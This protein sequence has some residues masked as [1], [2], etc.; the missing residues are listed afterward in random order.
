MTST[1]LG[2]VLSISLTP[3]RVREREELGS[4]TGPA[5]PEDSPDELGDSKRVTVGTLE[6]RIDDGTEATVS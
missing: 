3:R 6:R 5:L 1:L 2:L 4:E